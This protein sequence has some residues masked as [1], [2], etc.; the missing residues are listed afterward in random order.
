[1]DF[2][3]LPSVNA[4]LNATSALLLTLGYFFIRQR[5]V[6]AH[7]MTMIAAFVTSSLFLVSY[8]V[9]HARHGAT[10]F[11][12]PAW[13]RLPYFFILSTHTILAVAIVP[14]AA[15]TLYRG[16]RGQ[17]SRHVAIARLTLPIWLYVSVTGVL[18]YGMLYHLK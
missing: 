3:T 11:A 8:L 12:G 18:V 10:H 15:T 9:Y 5:A 16:L 1:M 7:T 13:A 2:S 4:G 14:L 6:T 17:F